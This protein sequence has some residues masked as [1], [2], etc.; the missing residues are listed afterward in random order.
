[1]EHSSLSFLLNYL[2]NKP[3]IRFFSTH[4][5]V[6]VLA[7]ISLSLVHLPRICG[8][9]VQMQLF[10]YNLH[11]FN[12][13]AHYCF[14]SMFYYFPSMFIAFLACFI[15]LMLLAQPSWSRI[16]LNNLFVLFAMFMCLKTFSFA[17]AM[18]M[19]LKVLFGGYDQCFYGFINLAYAFFLCLAFGYGVNLDLVVQ[20]FIHT[21]EYNKRFGLVPICMFVLCLL[22]Y[23][24]LCV[25]F[26]R[27]FLVMPCLVFHAQIHTF[28]FRSMLAYL[29]LGSCIL[30]WLHM[31]Y[32]PFQYVLVS[33][34]CLFVYLV[35]SFPL[36]WLV[37]MQPCG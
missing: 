27:S 11:P 12:F 4:Q 28:T 3:L 34:L 14:S 6:S 19:C 24:L 30:T 25:P 17:L 9:G 16:Y 35:A 22:F 21:P 5:E 8:L 2:L 20:A 1:M 18:I 29:D 13:I 7:L 31:L 37:W 33:L 10:S 32:F 26:V 23:M 36:L 15:T